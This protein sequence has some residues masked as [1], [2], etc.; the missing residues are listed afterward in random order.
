MKSNFSLSCVGKTNGVLN[1]AVLLSV[2]TGFALGACSAKDSGTQTPSAPHIQ[3][4]VQI[5]PKASQQYFFSKKS[6]TASGAPQVTQQMIP[7][8]AV[9][10]SAKSASVP[11]VS[12]KATV[13][14]N[15]LQNK[16][17][18]LNLKLNQKS[19][20][21]ATLSK[22][23]NKT[24]A[25]MS[26]RTTARLNRSARVAKISGKKTMSA[27]VNVINFDHGA[28]QVSDNNTAELNATLNQVDSDLKNPRTSP[29][30]KAA[31]K[32]AANTVVD[33][34]GLPQELG[35]AESSEA[36]GVESTQ[37]SPAKVAQDQALAYTSA[38]KSMK[39]MAKP[40]Y[41]GRALEADGLGAS[42]SY[43]ASSFSN[44]KNHWGSDG[45]SD[46][47][48]ASAAHVRRMDDTSFEN[49]LR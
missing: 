37:K 42:A 31:H 18:A 27:K 3:A 16:A 44:G 30:Q 24:N 23:S 47:Q 35:F 5:A 13:A 2:A 21:G 45:E 17:T 10:K 9:Q 14:R 22:V 33:T 4:Q 6:G 29:S 19:K 41:L 28:N 46:E 43:T 7:Q 48:V 20:T 39:Q 12:N 11:S 49:A 1:L 32:N 25:R 15:A 26:A 34:T 36:S 8:S 38:L 40:I